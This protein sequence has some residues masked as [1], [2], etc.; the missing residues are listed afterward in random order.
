MRSRKIDAC[1]A[2]AVGGD[3]ISRKTD[4]TRTELR[5]KNSIQRK[6]TQEC[7]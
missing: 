6:R 2:V 3:G 5:I 7:Y 1:S 4:F